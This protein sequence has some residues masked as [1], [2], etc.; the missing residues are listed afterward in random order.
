MNCVPLL[1][2]GTTMVTWEY[3]EAEYQSMSARSRPA[4]ALN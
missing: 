3:D 4:T 2:Y 1:D